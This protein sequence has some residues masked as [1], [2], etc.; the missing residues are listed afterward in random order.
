MALFKRVERRDQ[1]TI[2]SKFIDEE[3]HK[4]YVLTDCFGTGSM[5]HFQ[6]IDDENDTII[7]QWSEVKNRLRCFNLST[8]ELRTL[9]CSSMIDF[10]EIMLIEKNKK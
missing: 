7:M 5:F 10:L 2:G 1:L 9:L 6:D 3:R 4:I 8:F